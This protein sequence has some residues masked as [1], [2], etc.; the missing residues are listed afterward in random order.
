M[1]RRYSWP[2]KALLILVLLVLT[3]QLALPWL[4]RDYLNDKLA[5][6]GDYRG[7][8]GDIDLAW[9]HG[10]YRINELTIVK[11][12]GDVPVPLLDAPLID[13]SVSWTAL[14]RE[15]AVVGEVFFKRPQLNFVDGG[16]NE[17]A[18]QTG[19]GT[20]W[21]DQLNK[22]LPITLN[23]LRVIDGRIS[24]HNF[25]TDP[26]VELSANEVNASLYNLTNVGD[27]PGDRV[28]HFEGRAL[29]L[30]HAP[31]EAEAAFDPFEQFEDFELRLRARDI[32]LTRFNDFARAYGSF[33]FKRG[34]G[35]LVIEAQAENAQLN[36]YIKPL[37]HD[38]EVFDWEQDVEN[39]DKGVLRSIWEAIVGGTETL[40]KNQRRGQ[41]ATRV[42]LSGSV[43][44]QQTS[45]FQ[46]FI[47]I[48]RNGF[49]E[50]FTP[51]YE[52]RPP[53]QDGG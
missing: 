5:D 32:D 15:H 24:F 18:T 27:E 21:R 36:G 38:V 43:H 31:L 3:A 34:N 25:T 44:N 14:W 40:L 35:D 47:A 26:K 53:Q 46:A 17:Q 50:A 37:L 1:K 20:D 29:L 12:S 4:I 6:M 9:W 49:V 22:L 10:A 39:E 45:A 28:A 23:E 19:A 11:V 30:E 2:L 48:L 33:D 7:H 13:L 51:R 16:E 8:I 52:R 41:F 42:E